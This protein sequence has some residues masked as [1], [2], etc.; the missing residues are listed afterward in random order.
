MSWTLRP[1]LYRT[2]CT[3]KLL[4]GIFRIHCL[5]LPTSHSLSGPLQS[6]FHL[7]HL[8][9]SATIL[10]AFVRVTLVSTWPN[11]TVTS[12]TSSSLSSQHFTWPSVPPFWTFIIC[13]PRDYPL[14]V[15]SDISSPSISM[16]SK[17]MDPSAHSVLTLGYLQGILQNSWCP[18][19]PKLVLLQPFTQSLNPKVLEIFLGPSLSLIALTHQQTPS[20]QHSMP[21]LFL[22]SKALFPP[23]QTYPPTWIPLLFPSSQNLLFRW[24]PEHYKLDWLM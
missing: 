14:L 7:H 8:H 4:N 20:V 10:V 18:P 15:P 24:P 13:P 19:T 5:H 2:F 11:P 6:G 22:Q 3:T 16:N 1:P 9:H 23:L 17:T 21:P 12:Q